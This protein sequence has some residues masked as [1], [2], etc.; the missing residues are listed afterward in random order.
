M[1]SSQHSKLAKVGS[2]PSM[3]AMAEGTISNEEKIILLKKEVAGQRYRVEILEERI[4]VLA[5]LLAMKEQERRKP[6]IE[7]DDVMDL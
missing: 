3:L 4:V 6:M 7:R 1:E 2:T 5:E